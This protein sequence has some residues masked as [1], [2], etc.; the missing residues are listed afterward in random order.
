MCVALA[1]ICS[2]AR[3]HTVGIGL[4]SAL[5][6][7]ALCGLQFGGVVV[8]A[9]VILFSISILLVQPFCSKRGCIACG[10]SRWFTRPALWLDLPWE[11]LA[12]AYMVLSKSS[13]N[14]QLP[15]HFVLLRE[16][17]RNSRHFSTEYGESSRKFTQGGHLT[18]VVPLRQGNLLPR[19]LLPR[20]AASARPPIQAGSGTLSIEPPR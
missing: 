20:R 1:T 2:K 14:G 15:A 13:E 6:T 7:I 8:N 16:L 11:V 3:K 19:E 5:A 9:L 17:V 18:S 12:I 10:S 4:V